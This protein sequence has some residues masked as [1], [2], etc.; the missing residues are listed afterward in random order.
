MHA[1]GLAEER[2]TCNRYRVG[3]PVLF[4]WKNQRGDR[5]QGKGITRDISV[6]GAYVLSTT[7]PPANLPVDVEIILP[8]L[9]GASERRI[10]AKTRVLRVEN[11]V[12]GRPR[13]GFS[14]ISD[15]FT[16]RTTSRVRLKREATVKELPNP[17]RN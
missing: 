3:A 4:Y 8:P 5:F 1:T 14:V 10:Q 12:T 7:C 13:R 9:D 16:L 17:E 15:G 6:V 2:R 11:E